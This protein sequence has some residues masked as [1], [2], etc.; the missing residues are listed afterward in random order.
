MYPLTTHTLRWVSESI[1]DPSVVRLPLLSVAAVQ[2]QSGQTDCHVKSATQ[3]LSETSDTCPISPSF[4]VRPTSCL[5][6][7]EKNKAVV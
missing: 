1:T 2:A 6:M 7:M 3:G 4:A 5:S